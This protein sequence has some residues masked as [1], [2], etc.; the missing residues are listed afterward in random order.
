MMPIRIVLTDDHP[1]VRSG[2][3][4]L[5]EKVP[6]IVVIGEASDGAEALR[7]AAELAPDVLLLDMEMPG[8][9]GVE[10]ARQL[11]TD[12]SPVRVLALSAYDD[13]QYI[14]GLLA[15]GAAG[16]LTKE[17][18]LETIVE[19]VRGVA[20]GEEGWLSRRAAAQMAAWTRKG[21][22]HT[23][24]LTDRE[25]EV[26]RLVARGWTNEH[27]AEALSI[28]ERTIRFHLTNVYDKLGVSSRGEAIAWA[29]REGLEEQGAE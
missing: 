16:Y 28:S 24:G 21:P 15:S 27:V 17:E 23:S 5:L 8:Q 20:R 29:V 1:V 10:V 18:A 6:D 3:R 2:I 4:N 25:L 9:S 12:G 13:E 11:R 22:P 14:V 7:L 26:L 19:A